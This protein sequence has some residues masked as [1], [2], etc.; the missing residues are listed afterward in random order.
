VWSALTLCVYSLRCSPLQPPIFL[1][2]C[3]GS[4]G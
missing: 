4:S 2:D 1:L 3:L